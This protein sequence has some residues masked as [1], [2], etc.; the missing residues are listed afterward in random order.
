[1]H[2][3]I[4]NFTGLLMSNCIILLTSVDAHHAFHTHS[5]AHQPVYMYSFAQ[6][7]RRDHPSLMQPAPHDESIIIKQAEKG[8]GTG[9]ASNDQGSIDRLSSCGSM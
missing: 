7:Q 9:R 1:M 2:L 4:P 3:C 6:A 8:A 5:S